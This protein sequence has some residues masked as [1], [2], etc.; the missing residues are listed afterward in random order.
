MDDVKVVEHSPTATQG[1]LESP[2]ASSLDMEKAAESDVPVRP[3]HGYK[4]VN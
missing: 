1:N 4:V 2:Q 3:V